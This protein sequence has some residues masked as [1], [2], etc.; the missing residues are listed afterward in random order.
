MIRSEDSGVASALT[1]GDCSPPVVDA[2]N[3]RA[4]NCDNNKKSGAGNDEADAS[5][6]CLGAAGGKGDA[7]IVENGINDDDEYEDEDNDEEDDD[8][9]DEDEDDNA[10]GL[11]NGADES[12]G[13]RRRRSGGMM[14]R[15]RRLKIKTNPPSNAAKNGK[16]NK[17]GKKELA[18]RNWNVGSEICV[19]V[20]ALLSRK[21]VWQH[22]WLLVCFT[23]SCAQN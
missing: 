6:P 5:L 9:D 14:S 23:P 20:F 7:L 13:R 11:V 21:K 8:D 17:N 4:K 1:N 10:G 16:K 2:L 22:L 15:T 3:N 12:S 19:E 18:A